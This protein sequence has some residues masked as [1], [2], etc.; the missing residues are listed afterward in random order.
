MTVDDL[1]RLPNDEHCYELVDGRLDVS[2][3]PTSVHSS[4]ESRLHTQLEATASDQYVVLKSTGVNFNAEGTHHRVPDLLV[5]KA[6]DF[7]EPYLVQ[8]PLLVVEVVSRMSTLRDYHRKV[9]EYE[10]FGVQAYWIVDPTM[11][12][13]VINGLR[14]QDGEYREVRKAIGEDTFATDFPFPIKIVP[15]WLTVPGGAWRKFIGGEG[16]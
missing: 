9:C 3:A 11:D 16:D 8:P 5:I 13:P 6:D 1:E 7:V 10:R 4:V 14:L 2:P 15:R 12:T